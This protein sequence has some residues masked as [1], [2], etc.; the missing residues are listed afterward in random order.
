[1]TELSQMKYPAIRK[2]L[3]AGAA[4]NL[5]AIAAPFI[6]SATAART[7]AIITIAQKQDLRIEFMIAETA[8]WQ[9]RRTGLKRAGMLVM[10][11]RAMQAH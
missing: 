5:D 6:A 10:F 4:C 9:R 3:R 2:P 1:M 11:A 7:E 8:R